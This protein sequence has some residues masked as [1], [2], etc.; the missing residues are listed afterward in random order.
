[1]KF[2]LERTHEFRQTGAEPGNAHGL[3]SFLPGILIIG[4][5]GINFLEQHLRREKSSGYR[6]LGAAIAAQDTVAHDRRRQSLSGDARQHRWPTV[7]QKRN[8]RE[9]RA[10]HN[11]R[12]QAEIFRERFVL[13]NDA[14]PAESRDDVDATF[15]WSLPHVRNQRLFDFEWNAFLELPA[16]HRNRFLGRT[17]KLIE[18]LHEDADDGVRHK[19]RNVFIFCTQTAAD[20]FK[21]AFY[22]DEI[23]Q[24]GFDR[25]RYNRA[26]RQSLDSKAI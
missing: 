2:V 15:A 9:R 6:Q 20:T 10:K 24:I 8:C 4:R 22:G 11:T 7:G 14:E 13:A 18:V 3:D 17:R 12:A 23:D 25:G 19:N 26:G 16:K 1:M 5:D 21:G